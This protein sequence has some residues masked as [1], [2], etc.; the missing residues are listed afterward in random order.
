MT[1][2]MSDD[3]ALGIT[4]NVLLASHTGAMLYPHIGFRQ[5]GTL[6]IYNPPKGLRGT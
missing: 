5:F 2:T 1:R 4:N 6:Y 3:R